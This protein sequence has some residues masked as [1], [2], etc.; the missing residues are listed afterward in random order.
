MPDTSLRGRS[1]E[2]PHVADENTETQRGTV[3]CPRSHSRGW[4]PGLNPPTPGGTATEFSVSAEKVLYQETNS[5]KQEIREN[6]NNLR[7]QNELLLS[8]HSH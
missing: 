4:E 8:G 2:D 1:S 5:V 3:T 6:I 7:Q